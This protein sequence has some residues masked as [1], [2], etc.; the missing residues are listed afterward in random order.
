VHTAQV[1]DD[2]TCPGEQDVVQQPP[3]VGEPVGQQRL[4]EPD[5]VLVPTGRDVEGG[6]LRARLDD[7]LLRSPRARQAANGRTS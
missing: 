3:D 7:L 6:D 5:D 2:P 1:D 4:V